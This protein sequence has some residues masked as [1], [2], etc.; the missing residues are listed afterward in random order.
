[1]KRAIACVAAALVIVASVVSMAARR[2]SSTSPR[3]AT[4]AASAALTHHGVAGPAEPASYAEAVRVLS[5]RRARAEALAAR[6]P[7]SASRQ[8]Q[9]AAY[10]LDEG[11]LTGDYG[12]YQA[13]VRSIE[14]AFVVAARRGGSGDGAQ[15]SVGPH[16]LRAQIHFTLHRLRDAQVDLQA[17]YSEAEFFHDTTLHAETK[18]LAGATTFGLGDYDRGL[19][20]LREAVALAPDEASHAQRLA[21]AL[22]KI[23]GVD[24]AR[25]LLDGAEKRVH[26]PRGRAWLELQRSLL[27]LE[28]GERARARTHLTRAQTLFPGWW[29]V[30][31]RLAELDADEGRV[32]EATEGYRSLVTR[33]HD[34]EHIDALSRLLLD[35]EPARARALADEAQSLYEQRLTRLP[36]ATYGHGIEHFL[37]GGRDP[38]RTVE[39]AEK[40]VALRPDGEARSRLAQAY[41]TAGR[42]EEAARE[43]RKVIDSRWTSAESF[44]T[45]AWVL[46]RVGD[47]AGAAKARG[48]AIAIDPHAEARLAWTSGA[49]PK[50]AAPYDPPP[51]AAAGGGAH[52]CAEGD[53]D[54][55]DAVSAGVVPARG[56]AAQPAATSPT[57][58]PETTATAAEAVTFVGRIIGSDRATTPTSCLRRGAWHAAVGSRGPPFSRRRRPSR[59]E[60]AS[61]PT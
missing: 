55:A 18:A 26:A 34:P 25:T 31:E 48:R 3:A 61:H 22:A 24:E 28:R 17:P 33:T 10:A 36:E 45:A 15:V 5:E 23:G 29:L 40:N 30:D 19:A 59:S 13:A 32:V 14:L 12:A 41:A 2:K 20:L 51:P 8:A 47:R 9:V 56:L 54:E 42:L 52:A 58:R 7:E 37:L 35:R 53:T 49:R 43:I 16:L 50:P 44:A 38:K 27:D 60:L 4:T 1:M 6:S 21:L 46:E 39:I 11:Q 57:A